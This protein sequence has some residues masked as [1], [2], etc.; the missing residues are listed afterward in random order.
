[1]KYCTK[2]RY[3]KDEYVSRLAK[4][5][6]GLV[7]QSG[8]VKLCTNSEFFHP[9]NEEPLPCEAVRNDERFCGFEGRGWVERSELKLVVDNTKEPELPLIIQE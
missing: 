8:K 1:M 5:P 7:P 4:G 6:Q 9:I 3:S 2:C